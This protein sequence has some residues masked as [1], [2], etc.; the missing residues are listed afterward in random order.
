MTKEAGEALLKA[1]KDV[2]WFNWDDNDA[3]AVKAIEEL[4]NAVGA[5]EA[6]MIPE[7]FV[8]WCKP[9]QRN[10]DTGWKGIFGDCWR[11]ATK[12]ALNQEEVK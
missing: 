4:R 10:W 5:V 7:A 1:A 2:C 8:T 6:D 11:A 3:D 12:A 9:H